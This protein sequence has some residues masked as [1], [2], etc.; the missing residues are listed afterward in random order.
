[1]NMKTA[2]NQIKQKA[3]FTLIELLV[4]I[5]IIGVLAGV[6]VVVIDPLDKIRSANDSGVIS[7]IT[8]IGKANDSYGAN[9][10]NSYVGGTFANSVTDLNSSGETKYTALT[11]PTGYTYTYLPNPAACT[12]AAGTCTAYVYYT[13]LLSKRYTST[14][15]YVYANGKG[16]FN[17]AAPTLAFNCP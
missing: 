13:N 5:A 16:C 6:L 7:T 4:V 15:Y 9:H 17:A 14:P 1:M 8:Q 11:A 2:L 3:G 12:T 10:N